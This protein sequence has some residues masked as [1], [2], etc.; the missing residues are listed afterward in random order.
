[1]HGTKKNESRFTEVNA[2][3]SAQAAGVPLGYLVFSFLSIS[4]LFLFYFLYSHFRAPC[5]RI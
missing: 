1:M 3:H 2:Y 4:F 5:T